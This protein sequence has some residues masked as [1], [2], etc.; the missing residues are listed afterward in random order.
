MKKT[1]KKPIGASKKTTLK[2]MAPEMPKIEIKEVKTTKECCGSDC[3][4]GKGFGRWLLGL[5]LVLV[6]LVYL[7]KNTGLLPWD[8]NLS[9]GQVWP[10]IIVII[11]LSMI[12]RRSKLSIFFGIIIAVIAMLLILFLISFNFSQKTYDQ[13][14]NN[15]KQ[16]EATPENTNATSSDA[17]KV[18]DSIKI[19]NP[20]PNQKVSS[21]I[22][23]S[24]QAKGNW[25]FE[26]SFPVKLI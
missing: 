8:I 7:A 10:I 5:V 21:P 18:E 14:I 6:G 11:G 12:N 3:H 22:K 23:I 16:E 15:I 26:G 20:E 25:F 13:Q 9:W 17:V 2:T 4:C 19:A 24:G 1:V